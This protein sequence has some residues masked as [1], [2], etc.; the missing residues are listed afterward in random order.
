M[1]A[2]QLG[3]IIGGGE[4]DVFFFSPGGVRVKGESPPMSSVLWWEGGINGRRWVGAIARFYRVVVHSNLLLSWL[5]RQVNVFL[6][7]EF[8]GLWQLL[9]ARY[10]QDMFSTK[11]WS[12]ASL[13][14]GYEGSITFGRRR[15]VKYWCVG[16]F[17]ERDW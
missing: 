10:L 3:L 9:Q 1:P 16:G 17:V 8:L 2:H 11:V 14:G 12:L 5:S 15:G 4:L 13:E 7:D 6:R